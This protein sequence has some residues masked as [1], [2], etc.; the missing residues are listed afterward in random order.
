MSI[1]D[2]NKTVDLFSDGI[3]RFILKNLRNE[4]AAQDI[5]QDTYEKLWINYKKIETGKAKSWLF[6]AAYH[7][8]I[9]FLRREKRIQP[10]EIHHEN[11]FYYS[12]EY[13]GTGDLIEEGLSHLPSIQKSVVMLRD[14]E[15]YS[16]EEIGKIT[17]LSES[18][19]KVYIHRARTFLRM[20]ILKREEYYGN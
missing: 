3:Y 8:M 10:L 4:E 5:V 7:T 16:Y 12:T 13:S 9:D 19:V 20:F 6:T 15:G 1:A 14:Y 2:Y 18:Q 17:D 11:L